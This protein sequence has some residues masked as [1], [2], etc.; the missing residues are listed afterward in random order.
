MDAI[1]RPL[2][3]V[4]TQGDT[5]VL[6]VL[7]DVV[8]VTRGRRITDSTVHFFYFCYVIAFF[9]GWFIVH[10]LPRVLHP[11]RVATP[12]TLRLAL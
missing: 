6:F 1:K 12:Q 3:A 7:D 8:C 11:M 5:K 10:K 4:F 9:V 2:V